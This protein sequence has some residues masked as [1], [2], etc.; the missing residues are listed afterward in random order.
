M[1]IVRQSG[2]L[3]VELRCAVCAQRLSLTTGWF[4]FPP[5]DADN[6]TT[7]RWLHRRCLDTHVKALF[8]TAA[9]TLIRADAVFECMA[10]SLSD[11]HTS[12]VMVRGASGEVAY[13]QR[14]ATGYAR[15]T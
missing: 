7:G 5:V 14:A 9:V 1:T 13:A 4:A 11:T 8:G 12:P 6:N 2:G 10:A 15:R 3:T